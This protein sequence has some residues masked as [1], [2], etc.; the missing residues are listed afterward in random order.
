MTTIYRDTRIAAIIKQNKDGIEAIASLAA[1]LAKLRN[2]LLRKLLAGRVTVAEAVAM[3]GS[4]IAAFAEALRPLGFEL[5]DRDKRQTGEKE[6]APVT[7]GLEQW[8][9]G[10]PVTRLDV[11]GDLA[12]GQDPLKRITETVRRL[13][14]DGALMLINSFEPAPL[15]TLLQKQGFESLVEKAGPDEVHTYFRRSA[16]AKG[17]LTEQ[18]GPEFVDQERFSAK[19]KEFDGR[20]ESVDVSGMEMPMPMVTILEALSALPSGHVLS[21]THKR[22]PVFLFSEL[23]ERGFSYLLCRQGDA[24]IRLLIFREK[25]DG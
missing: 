19:Q 3:G 8:L 21:V 10:R 11:R 2:P 7:G 12:S 4:S 5:V 15:I 24:D 18:E 1:P 22:V 25:S 17:S 6:A 13:P 23:R 16:E 20:V 14:P 9:D